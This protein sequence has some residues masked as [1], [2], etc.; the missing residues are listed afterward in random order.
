[1]PQTLANYNST[2]ILTDSNVTRDL[3]GK[4]VSQVVADATSGMIPEG[5]YI[6][7]P[8]ADPLA[9]VPIVDDFLGQLAPGS[10][11]PYSNEVKGEQGFYGFKERLAA[12]VFRV[13]KSSPIQDR[14]LLLQKWEGTVI[15]VCRDSFIARLVDLTERGAD[16]EAEFDVDEVSVADRPLIEAGSVFYWSI[17][18]TDTAGGQRKR[19]STIRFRRLP[20]WT[21]K[22]LEEAKN[23]AAKTRALLDW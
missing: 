16:E 7:Y 2:Q 22:E 19:M 5:G 12:S 4:G 17:G 15:E 11:D 18:Y 8:S 21:S 14:F 3:I 10:T 23:K 13:E 9:I 20:M 6:L 1:M